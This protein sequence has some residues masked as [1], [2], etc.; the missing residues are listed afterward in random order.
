VHTLSTSGPRT[1]QA[2]TLPASPESAL[3]ATFTSPSR[4]LSASGA[5]NGGTVEPT[6]NPRDPGPLL[7]IVWTVTYA[8]SS[9]ATTPTNHV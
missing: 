6:F 7:E 5:A 1:L 4:L 9:T 2:G 8:M 3:R